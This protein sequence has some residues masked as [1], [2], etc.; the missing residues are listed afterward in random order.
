MIAQILWPYYHILLNVLFGL[1]PHPIDVPVKRR[2][3]WRATGCSASPRHVQFKSG[4]AA[5]ARPHE[6]AC[7]VCSDISK[8][9][10]RGACR[11]IDVINEPKLWRLMDAKFSHCFWAVQCRAVVG[12]QGD[13]DMVI[14]VDVN[15]WLMV[16]VDGF[17]HESETTGVLGDTLRMQQERDARFK[18]TALEKRHRVLRLHP[19]D[20][21]LWEG[22][23]AQAV[24]IAGGQGEWPVFIASPNCR[25]SG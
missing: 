4:E 18:D 3:F 17:C 1:P 23:I 13:V 24:D 5:A 10:K 9:G 19:D 14:F 20:Y 25:A 7:I 11:P 2:V 16:Q 21:D 12:W 8:L 6:L 22:L 15:H